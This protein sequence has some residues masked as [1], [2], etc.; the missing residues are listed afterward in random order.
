MALGPQQKLIT[1]QAA[2]HREQT[3]RHKAIGRAYVRLSR[4]S[5]SS[6]VSFL[7]PQLPWHLLGMVVSLVLPVA[8]MSMILTFL[9]P[10]PVPWI[11]GSR[12]T[13]PF[14]AA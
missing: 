7:F 11:I 14:L 1:P 12:M 13:L 5:Q 6:Q 3:G 4:Y 10:F 8:N 2:Q 9:M